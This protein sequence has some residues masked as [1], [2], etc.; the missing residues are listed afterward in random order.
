MH[1]KCSSRSVRSGLGVVGASALAAVASTLM[2]QGSGG[3]PGGGNPSRFEN[4]GQSACDFY[5][6]LTPECPDVT[7]GGGTCGVQGNA[8]G[9]SAIA[10]ANAEC[11]VAVRSQR[12][13][14]ECILVTTTGV[15]VGCS[16]AS[17]AACP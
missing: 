9:F 7:L 17:G 6:D 15:A 2:A 10:P 13:Q 5:V 4:T 14:G 3:G 12:H 8:S 11:I 1:Q 16:V